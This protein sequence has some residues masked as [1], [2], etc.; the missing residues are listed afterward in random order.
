LRATKVSLPESSAAAYTNYSM[1]AVS[2]P[3]PEG[4]YDLLVNGETYRIVFSN[5]HWLARAA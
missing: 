4:D 3:L 5:G 2:Q 1:K